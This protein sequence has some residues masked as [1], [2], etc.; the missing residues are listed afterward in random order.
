VTVNVIDGFLSA[1]SHTRRAYG[2]GTPVGGAQFDS[3]GSLRELETSLESAASGSLWSGSAATTY[4]EAN[5]RQRRVIGQLAGLDHRLA[6]E[7]DHSA[8]VVAAGRR[9]LDDVRQR[10]VAAATSAPAGQSG[11][12]VKMAIARRGLAQIQAIVLR[13]HVESDDIGERIRGLGDEYQALDSTRSEEPLT[14]RGV[15]FTSDIPEEPAPLVPGQPLDPTNPFIGDQRFGHWE[16]VIALPYTGTIPSPLT[17]QYR[18]FPEGTP[19]KTGGTT[20]WYTPERNWAAD[21]PYAQYQEAYRF[22]IAGQE[23]TTYTRTVRQNG[24][25]QQERWVQNVYEF[26]KNTQMSF[27]GDVSVRGKEGDIGGLTLLPH[28]DYEWKPIGPNEIATLSATNAVTTYYLPDG[29]GGQFTYQGGVPVG[30]L[31]GLPSTPPIMTRPR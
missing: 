2:N 7:I 4:D 21:E 15:D 16:N 25:W 5:T 11:E 26:Q 22:R 18:P 17:R 9:D 12:R 8:Q 31:S 6:S 19:L 3:S 14:V 10:V 28:I 29:C 23:A 20:G 1:W 30:G 13:S 27:S 24:R